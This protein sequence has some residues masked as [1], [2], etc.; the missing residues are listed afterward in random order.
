MAPII[1][2]MYA[3]FASSFSV[4][5]VL[6]QY[7]S[8]WFVLGT[9]FFLAGA[10]LLSYQFLWLKEKIHFR[11]KHFWLYAQITLLGIYASYFF[12][13][14]GLKYLTST[15]TSLIFNSTPFFAA[16][17]SYI[18][19]NERLTKKQW[20]GLVIGF[21]GLV[22]ILITGSYAEQEIGEFLYISWPEL[23][24]LGAVA[25]QS[26]SWI[27][28][29]KLVKDKDHSPIVVNGI[30]MAIGGT[31]GLVTSFIFEG[32]S[33]FTSSSFFWG[34][35][36]YVVIVSNIICYNLYGYLLRRYSATFVSFAGF[37]V[38]FFT[39]LY[40]WGFLN[41]QITWHFYVSCF[42]VFIGLY[43]FYQD[44][45]KDSSVYS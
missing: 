34:W 33:S 5:K 1:L 44:E 16:L 6:L 2:F 8:E 38:P 24:V 18:L 40:G 36:F 42:I 19:F 27:I 3:L 23:S 17:Y 9:R 39:A 28:V 21:L 31:L 37:I 11:K 30:T 29:R 13:F 12:R 25:L 26:Y 20:I 10:I 14:Y 45:L 41:E 32:T 43:L 15:K 4:G 22:P 35:L 7:S